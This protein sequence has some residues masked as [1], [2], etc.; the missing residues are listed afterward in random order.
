[1]PE[2][3]LKTSG[4]RGD[5][6]TPRF[7]V[8]GASESGKT[9]RLDAD[10]ARGRGAAA[11]PETGLAGLIV[12]EKLG[13]GFEVKLSLENR[14]PEP[15]L[16]REIIPCGIDVADMKDNPARYRWYHQGWSIR[17]PS[18]SVALSSCERRLFPRIPGW[19]A[20][21][22]L[23]KMFYRGGELPS[24]KAGQLSS[25]AVGVLHSLESGL[26][27]LAG[28]LIDGLSF[29]EVRVSSERG[30]LEGVIRFDS[31]LILAPGT[32]TIAARLW[33]A[34]GGDA[35]ELL[36]EYAAHVAGA[37][38]VRVR[39]TRYWCSWY[40]GPYE[41]ISEEF[42]RENAAALRR[43]R[44]PVD[45]LIVDRGYQKALGDWLDTSRA[46]PGG[47][48]AIVRAIR[49]AGFSPGIWVA[50][51][52]VDRRSSLAAKHPE[53]ILRDSKGKP[54]GAGIAPRG[55][56]PFRH[57][58]LD[59]SRDE[60]LAWIGDLFRRMVELG[61]TY[62]KT[63]FLVA[64]TLPGD[65]ARGGEPA[66]HLRRA[67][68]VAREAVGEG[69]MLTAV[70]PFPYAAGL[71][72][73]QRL[74]ADA[75]YGLPVY[76]SW[77]ERPLRNLLLPSLRVNALGALTRAWASEVLFSGDGDCTVFKNL[78]ESEILL[79]AVVHSLAGR[80]LSVG[81][82]F[83]RGLPP[84]WESVMRL[85][86]WEFSDLKIPD[87]MLRR[88][89]RCAVALA[90]KGNDLRRVV[91]WFNWDGRPSHRAWQPWP[92][93]ATGRERDGPEGWTDFFDG[94]PAIGARGA[95]VPIPG[96]GCRLFMSPPIDRR[97]GPCGST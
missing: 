41:R 57:W 16:I 71:A 89:P 26:S 25:A 85:W 81:H 36:R 61:Y 34:E 23:R 39:P 75:S 63:D 50:P 3:F 32:E 31:P 78:S 4:E 42:I 7:A 56:I 8:L 29:P 83:R 54:V 58:V 47:H 73:A 62:F 27:L 94:G 44:V 24:K 93:D 55:G 68:E 38:R 19:L 90:R 51:F 79:G 15:V 11:C 49:D 69:R 33:L 59:V 37:H 18:A 45:A 77:T 80:T 52:A 20:P 48:E 66:A 14:G 95:G 88:Y 5:L 91:A 12:T 21:E 17:A 9:V 1:M 13:G 87:L 72:D 10:A 28:F 30:T 22:T 74:G 84:G 64:A 76:R 60:V 35:W 65:H 92:T 6:F 40:S 43:Q 46:F 82:D 2:S 53:W 67:M 97:P 86:D 70:M 96:H